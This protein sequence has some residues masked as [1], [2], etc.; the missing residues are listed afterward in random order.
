[1]RPYYSARL[2]A[3]RA[4]VDITRASDLD[5]DMYFVAWEP[6][7][8]PSTEMEPVNRAL[9]MSAAG[10][11]ATS[12]SGRQ[13]SDMPRSAVQTFLQLQYSRL[14]GRMANEW[15][16]AVEKTADLANAEFPRRLVPLIEAAL[17][18]PLFPS[19]LLSASP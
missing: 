5:G 13:L 1:M 14:L 17:V 10:H 11:T 7:L 12:A 15:T 16:K 4:S 2:V 6:T 8:I 3:P 18:R 19:I 9:S